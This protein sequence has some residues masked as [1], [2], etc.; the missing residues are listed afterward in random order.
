MPSRNQQTGARGEDLAAAFLEEKGYVILDRN[1]RFL[2]AEVDLVAFLPTRDYTRGGDLVFVEVKW[3]R[4]GQFGSPE[5]AVDAVKKRNL[6]SVAEAWLHE[7][8]MEG[9][10]CRFDVI[11]IRG[12]AT[13]PRITH[14]EHAFVG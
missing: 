2:R 14:F 12:D 9:T 1:Y 5:A 7:R 13:A 8:K 6:I 10:P 4:N 11:S 3:R